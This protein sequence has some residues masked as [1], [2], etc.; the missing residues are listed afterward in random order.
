MDSIVAIG[1]KGGRCLSFSP[2]YRG[3]VKLTVFISEIRVCGECMPGHSMASHI[4]YI[5]ELKPD[6]DPQELLYSLDLGV[7]IEEV[8]RRVEA[9]G[10]GAV[11]LVFVDNRYSAISWKSF[12]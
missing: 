6:F 11:F 7:N 4:V 8:I 1:L 9:H 12:A 10:N 3:E 2:T 5:S